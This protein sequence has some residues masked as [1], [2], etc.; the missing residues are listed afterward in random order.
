GKL[1]LHNID[2][3]TDHMFYLQ[4]LGQKPLA[5]DHIEMECLAGE[6][7]SYDIKVPNVTFNKMVYRAVSDMAIISGPPV[8]TVLPGQ[9]EEYTI[10]AAPWKRGTFKGIISFIAGGLSNFEEDSDG[11]EAKD[12]NK[13]PESGRSAQSNA[14][15]SSISSVSKAKSSQDKVQSKQGYRVWYSIGVT[16][17]PPKPEK[18]LEITC[19]AQV[20]LC[21]LISH[22]N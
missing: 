8:L 7:C 12:Q 14:S 21:L 20:S 16:S 11:E 9:E 10:T 2:N 5:L 3:N 19:A 1:L 18:T 13:R 17:H 4:G 6:K 15:K 22:N